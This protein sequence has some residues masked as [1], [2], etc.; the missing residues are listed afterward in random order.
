MRSDKPT[1]L[2]ADKG[3]IPVPEFVA[4]E[5]LIVNAS[6]LVCLDTFGTGPQHGP[7]ASLPTHRSAALFIVNGIVQ[8]FGE[9]EDVYRRI[10]ANASLTVIDATGCTIVPGFVDPHAHTIYAGSRLDEFALR[11]AGAGYDEISAQGGGVKRTISDTAE[12][13]DT[14]LHDALVDR[15]SL[16]LRLGTTT[17][18]VK[19][20]YWVDAD[21]ERRALELVHSL[22]GGHPVDLVPTYHVALGLPER[23]GGSRESFAEYVI[24]R[25]I[26]EIASHAA[27]LDVVCDAS[28][29]GGFSAAQCR[30]LIEAGARQG[31][32]IK[33]HADEFSAAGG[34]DLAASSGAVSADHLCYLGPST[35]GALA[36]S[37]T[38]AVLLPVT[39]H[40]KLA[41]KLAD[42]RSLV[43]AGVAV[44]L[45]TDH[46]P[47]N[48][49]LSM[50]FV[51]GLACAQLQLSPAEALVAATWNAACALAS[52]ETAGCI[53]LG[54]P[55]D[56]VVLE[57][58][59]YREIPCFI[60]RPLVRATIKKGKVYLN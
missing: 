31:L 47:S 29:A 20:G 48:P 26:P 58:E 49:N 50:P 59:S 57:A 42:A 16:A 45:G 36:A 30:R 7:L 10:G 46:G 34:G 43:E 17:A 2:A 9:T 19:T 28:D 1:R 5:L 22:D 35:A 40:Y 6:E 27:F 51:I 4:S 44:A 12:A 21:K 25:A 54:R 37:Q 18:E 60:D 15:L 38:V 14:V 11:V 41:P 56:L 23:F 13:A 8:D 39:H 32:K 33:I 3:R 55:A 24:Q 53:K 52:Q